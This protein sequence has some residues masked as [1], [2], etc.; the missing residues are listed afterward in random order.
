MNPIESG[1]MFSAQAR[2]CIPLVKTDVNR[3]IEILQE[4]QPSSVGQGPREGRGGGE[5]RGV[6]EWQTK[7]Y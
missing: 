6:R 5:P 2:T 7:K 1:T 4:K 3:T